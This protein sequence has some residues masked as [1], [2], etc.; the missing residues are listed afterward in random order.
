[1]KTGSFGFTWVMNDYI[2]YTIHWPRVKSPS[3]I[4]FHRHKNM[5]PSFKDGLNYD[6]I[7][8][9]GISIQQLCHQ[10]YFNVQLI[11]FFFIYLQVTWQVNEW[12]FVL[13][14]NAANFEIELTS[15]MLLHSAQIAS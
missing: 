4:S 8:L 11:G 1:M 3:I 15:S 9:I 5:K 7:S 10:I 6:L 14:C 12:L 2:D 13:N